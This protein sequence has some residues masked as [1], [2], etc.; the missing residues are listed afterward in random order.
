[1]VKAKRR[2]SIEFWPFSECNRVKVNG[3]AFISTC[4]FYFASLL[5][6]GECHSERKE[7][8]FLGA[9]SFF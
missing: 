4:N 8:A 9:N 7:F 2:Y 5:S 1:M 6:R 3:H